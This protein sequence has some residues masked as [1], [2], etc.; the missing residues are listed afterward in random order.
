MGQH[1]A[2]RNR[3]ARKLPKEAGPT[4]RNRHD[5]DLPIRYA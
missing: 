3:G 1:D 2:T 5:L 4:A